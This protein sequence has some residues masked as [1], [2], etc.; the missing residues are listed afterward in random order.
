[1]SDILNIQPNAG[2]TPN[3]DTTFDIEGYDDHINH[4]EKQYPTEEPVVHPEIQPE[5]KPETTDSTGQPQQPTQQQPK[6]EV[7]PTQPKEISQ[8]KQQQQQPEPTESTG[9]KLFDRGIAKQNQ[10]W[11]VDDLTGD[12]KVDSIRD[13]EGR[14][15]IDLPNGR[16]MIYRNSLHKVKHAK[17]DELMELLKGNNLENKLIAH[18]MIIEDEELVAR[19]DRNKDG[20]MTYSD[21]FDVTH[22]NEGKGLSAEEDAELTQE[23]LESLAAPDI[24]AR[25]RSLYQT[26]HAGQD[27]VLYTLKQRHNYFNPTAEENW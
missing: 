3:E 14:K 10:Y 23:W 12:L 6:P 5:V 26:F 25:L 21:F 9:N 27:M 17:E 24:G 13:G 16:E 1:M 15:L 8:P 22:I 11:E 7:Q 4:L 18:Q 19:L 2:Q 20:Q